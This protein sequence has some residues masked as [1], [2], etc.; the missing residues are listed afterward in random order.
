MPLAAQGPAPVPQPQPPSA[1]PSVVLAQTAK[2]P[3]ADAPDLTKTP[4]LFVVGYAHLDTEWR[5]DYP[6][7]INEYLK[8]TLDKNFDLI[9]KYPHYIFNFTGANRYGM[10]KE[11]YPERYAQLKQY[12]AQGRWFPGGASMEEN[13][14]NSP[15][16]ESILRQVLYGNEY[17]R[18]EFG[19]IAVDYMLPDCF[20]FPASLPSILSHAGLLGFSTQKLNSGWQPAA[21][22]GGP[23]SPEGT[24]EGIPFNVGVW[25]GPDG[26]SILGAVNPG[27]YDGGV[28]TDLSKDPLVNLVPYAHGRDAVTEDGQVSGL[29]TDYHYVGTGDIGG[30]P[31][32]ESVK[33]MEA[34]MDHGTIALPRPRPRRSRANPNPPQ[35]PPYPAAEVGDGP[36]HVQWADT[37]SMF[38][39]MKN[40]DLSR[41]PRYTGDLE[42][43]NHSAGSLTSEAAHKRW[44]R[45]NEILAHAAE[46]ASVGAS[47]L[48]RAYPQ[49]RLTH[50]WRLLLGGQFHDIMAGTAE[51]SSYTYSWN[52]D[53]I[54]ANQ[55]A[56]VLTSAT[57]AISSRLDTAVGGV[58]V[59]VFNPLN[60]ARQDPVEAR[61]SLPAGTRAVRVLS[62]AG[63]PVPAQLDAD[64]AVVFLAAVPATGYA[65]YS[66][67]PA[68]SASA[69]GLKVTERSL[70]N[71]RYRVTL[72]DDGD[73]AS[74]FDKHIGKELLAAPMR[75]SFQSEAPSVWPAWNMDWNDQKAPPRAYVAGPAQISILENGP[76]RATLQIIRDGEGSHFVQTVSLASGTAGDR[77]EFGVHVDWKT[78][79]SALMADFPLTASDP[80]ATYNWDIGTIQRPNDN[81]RQF[82][83]ASHQWVDLTD[84][85]QA[86]GATVLT[87]VKN[88]SD[89][90]NDHAL[91]LTLL[92]TPGLHN[93]NYSD[94]ATQD[95]GH[96]DIAFGLAGHEGDWRQEG[97]EWQA[98]R[99]NVPLVAFSAPKHAGALGRS[100]SLL[101]LDNPRIRVL[102]M[103]KAESGGD[104]VVRLVELDGQAEPGVHIGFA[105]RALSVREVN[106]QEQPIKA[107]H[108]ARVVNGEVVASFTAYQP[109]S[110][111]IKLA[112]LA[113][114]AAAAASQP[115]ALSYD[116]AAA[117]ADH[118]PSSTGFD[119]KGSSYPAEMLPSTVNYAGIQFRLGDASSADAVTTHGQTIAL[120]AGHFTRLYLLASALGDQTATF[121]VGSQPDSLNIQNWT[122]YIGQWDYR[123]WSKH[124][125]AGRGGR[126]STYEL[127]AGLHPGYIKRAPL[128]WFASHHHLPDGSNDAYSY[129]Y[130]FAY[131][132]PI[133]AGATSLTLP[134]NPSVRVFA[135][136][137]AGGP[138]P[139]AAAAPLYDMLPSPYLTDQ[140]R[141]LLYTQSTGPD[142]PFYA[143]R[144]AASARGRN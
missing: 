18:K 118:T 5:W 35:P 69:S 86:Y 103:K 30:S 17:F 8:A 60:I 15:N 67:A 116:L 57:D 131:E 122:G 68:A 38:L 42:L 45:K 84:A 81:D 73:V 31:D 111:E 44:N 128:A 43:I 115:V 19:K 133:P 32:E 41:L 139:V 11:Y 7:V 82:E 46:E 36:V 110:L 123:D 75:L 100:L 85:S 89:K 25:T 112:P 2:Q 78:G 101:H 79:G 126:S 62:P 64:G 99:L 74:I 12:I 63:A 66:I 102:A 4:T 40:D 97:T 33:I 59:V 80:V 106:G 20:G 27:S 127:Y 21:R 83:V 135:A 28:T 61:V 134:D 48:G 98:Y 114:T 55:L 16:A 6:Q 29:Y 108:P 65:V 13:D 105:S 76:A 49:D 143:P 138:A 96:H 120:P 39:D 136:T 144:P 137:V 58:P 54:V 26:R 22:V 121:T 141:A 113:A 50:A 77:V 109:R 119:G 104:V 70:E 132:L 87:D 95:W 24:P 94:Q 72:N 125:Q 71:S 3:P 117:T 1:V 129:S 52:D 130:L 9:Q 56:Q 92:Y 107:D 140:G 10:F 88:A 53:T 142:A 93:R 47:L 90:P 51:A 34:I 124:T 91:R 23:T 14:V 37:D